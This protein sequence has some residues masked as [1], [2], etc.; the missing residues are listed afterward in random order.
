MVYAVAAGSS[1]SI[2]QPK[3]MS[4]SIASV[5]PVIKPFDAASQPEAGISALGRSRR[6][7]RWPGARQVGQRG[8]GQMPRRQ[9]FEAL[10]P[11]QRDQA[12]IRVGAA[13]RL[14]PK[15]RGVIAI[16]HA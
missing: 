9:P 6:R 5:P 12:T 3:A 11:G 7:T 4:A 10:A 16:H 2:E 13:N 15:L 14:A 1:V 8:G